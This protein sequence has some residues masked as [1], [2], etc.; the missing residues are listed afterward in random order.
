L[1]YLHDYIER[2]YLPQA[3]M[4]YLARLGWSYDDTREIFSPA[5]LIEL[6]TLEQVNSSPASHDQDKLYWLEGEWMKRLDT[7]AK[8]DGVIPFLERE[9]LIETPVTA[10]AGNRIAS[11]VTA[12]G[13][14]LKVFSDIVKLGRFFFTDSVEWDPVAVKK[15]LKGPGAPDLLAQLASLLERTE[16]YDLISLETSVQDFATERGLKLGEV[17]NALRVA[18]TGQAV[19]PGLYDCLVILGRAECLGRIAA[20]RQH[21]R[22]EGET[23]TP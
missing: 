5:E 21:L 20:A 16:P 1:L 23:A 22:A 7:A 2:G 11:V 6:F 18:V 14:R 3:I 8:V 15:R 17:V 12:L 13:D 10:E 4:N 19:G 9:G